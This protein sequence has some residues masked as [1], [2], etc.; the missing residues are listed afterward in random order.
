MQALQ[1]AGQAADFLV[2]Q[3]LGD[4]GHH[5]VEVRIRTRGGACAVHLQLLLGVLGVLAPQ[6][7]V[8][9]AWVAAAVR[10][11]AGHARRNTAVGVAGAIELLADLV[12]LLVRIRSAG[13]Q[14]VVGHAGTRLLGRKVGTQVAGVLRA[15]HVGEGF[16]DRRH[17]FIPLA[18]LE[19]RQL[20]RDIALALAGDARVHRDSGVSVQSVAGRTGAGQRLAILDITPGRMFRRRRCKRG[21]LHRRGVGDRCHRGLGIG[22]GRRRENG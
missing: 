8:G 16:H 19:Q 13:H 11:V 4:G 12:E 14:G 6:M 3:L 5:L 9:R 21:G 22:D 17:P 20:V 10:A 7:R 2:R 18:A 1:I 15:E